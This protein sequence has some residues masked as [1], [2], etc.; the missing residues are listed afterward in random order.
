MFLQRTLAW[1]RRRGIRIRRLLTDNAMVYGP[2]SPARAA[3]AGPCVSAS[4]GR[5][6]RTRMATR[7]VSFK[8]CCASG[9]ISMPNRRSPWMRFQEAA[10]DEILFYIH[11]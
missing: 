4:P 6:P 5:I 9:P 11:T 2:A 1:C 3:D 7:S 8:R 10:Q